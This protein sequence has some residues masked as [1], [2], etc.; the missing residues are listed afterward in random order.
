MSSPMPLTVNIIYRSQL[1]AQWESLVHIISHRTESLL[2]SELGRSEYAVYMRDQSFM[3]QA[4]LEHFTT[5]YYWI[6]SSRVASRGSYHPY[7]N[8]DLPSPHTSLHKNYDL[9]FPHTP[10]L[11]NP[12]IVHVACIIRPLPSIPSPITT[13]VVP[14]LLLRES[15]IASGTC[16]LK[17]FCS[18]GL[19]HLH[20]LIGFRALH[21]TF[22][23]MNRITEQDSVLVP[24][25]ALLYPGFGKF[26]DNFRRFSSAS[27]PADI[28][29]RLRSLVACLKRYVQDDQSDLVR[30]TT[31]S[32]IFGELFRINFRESYDMTGSNEGFA[33]LDECPEVCFLLKDSLGHDDEIS[34][35]TQVMKSH[36]RYETGNADLYRGYCVPTLGIVVGGA[37]HPDPVIVTHAFTLTFCLLRQA[38]WLLRRHLPRHTI[39]YALDTNAS[40]QFRRRLWRAYTGRCIS[41]RRHPSR[42]HPQRRQAYDAPVQVLCSTRA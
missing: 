14:K 37:E 15:V 32:E 27:S 33:D 39:H 28:P 9:L 35:A 20:C 1:T 36:L 5:D 11:A 7:I 30:D 31:T 4:P 38:S 2:V 34:L 42:G 17:V 24:P 25:L 29:T 13:E 41:C 23:I 19:P 40:H 16:L 10:E 8:G 3:L 21:L 6:A 22:R 26:S 12:Y 18:Y